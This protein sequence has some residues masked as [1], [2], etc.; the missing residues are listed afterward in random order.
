MTTELIPVDPLFHPCHVAI[1]AAF[2]RFRAA[3]HDEY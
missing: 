3:G 2:A 1:T